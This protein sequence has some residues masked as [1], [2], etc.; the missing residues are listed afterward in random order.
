MWTRRID[1]QIAEP[2]CNAFRYSEGL[3]YFKDRIRTIPHAAADLKQLA[4]DRITWLDGQMAGKQ[5]VCGDRFTLADILLFAFLEFAARFNQP[6][7]PNNKNIVAWY[8]RVEARPSASIQQ[9]SSGP[10]P[11]A[12][13]SNG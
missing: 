5:F 3:E 2:S 8:K 13:S 9:F 10:I 7:N 4:Q 1:L 11:H 6:L 12:S